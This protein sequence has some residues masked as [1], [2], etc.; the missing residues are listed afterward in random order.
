MEEASTLRERLPVQTQHVMDCSSEKG[1]SNWLAV[2]PM[3]EMIFS[4]NKGAFR[5]AMSYIMDGSLHTCH[6]TVYVA[7]GKQLN[8]LSAAHIEGYP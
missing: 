3:H 8:I 7:R 4:L 2:L 1:S 6:P 5:D